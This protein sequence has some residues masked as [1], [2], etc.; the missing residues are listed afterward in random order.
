MGHMLEDQKCACNNGYKLDGKTCE[1]PCSTQPFWMEPNKLLAEGDLSGDNRIAIK[2]R[3]RSPD[4]PLLQGTD[5]MPNLWVNQYRTKYG[6]AAMNKYGG[7][8][9]RGSGGYYPNEHRRTQNIIRSLRPDWN[10]QSQEPMKSW[11]VIDEWTTLEFLNHRV[12]YDGQEKPMCDVYVNGLRDE[13]F[14]EWGGS[15]HNDP[16]YRSSSNYKLYGSTPDDA[17]YEHPPMVEVCRVHLNKINDK[18][19][20]CADGVHLC[21]QNANCVGTAGNVEYECKCK[22]GFRHPR[23]RPRICVDD[24]C[25]NGNHNCGEN[26]DCVLLTDYG[27]RIF[28]EKSIRKRMDIP[29]FPVVELPDFGAQYEC[30]CKHEFKKVRGQCVAGSTGEDNIVLPGPYRTGFEIL[31]L[32]SLTNHKYNNVLKT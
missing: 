27:E 28:N 21:D 22:P 8:S 30:Q 14:V 24:P 7:N 11:F 32:H 25:Q 13:R 1:E 18:M 12:K 23:G 29:E 3:L 10:L 26:A 31:Y 9:L 17:K 15:P 16:L 6:S 2:M 5:G 4:G 20:I 19:D